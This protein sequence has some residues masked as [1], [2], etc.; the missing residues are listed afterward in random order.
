VLIP[1]VLIAFFRRRKLLAPLL[2]TV[3]VESILVTVLKSIY[4]QPRPYLLLDHIHWLIHLKT[5]SFPSG[6]AAIAFAIAGVMLYREH[7][8]L[9]AAW[10][11][12]ALLIAYERMYVG[13][14]FPLD[15]TVGALLGLCCARVTL[16][17]TRKE[18]PGNREQHK[19][20]CAPTADPS[21]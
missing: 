17:L 13:V 10:L 2:I 4:H 21:R 12:Y 6:D 1:V 19:D 16:A 3:A 14:H 15:V 9:K 20:V 11:L 5:D 18:T 8:A 7:W